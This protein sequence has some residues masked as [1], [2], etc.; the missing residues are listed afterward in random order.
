MVSGPSTIEEISIDL[1]LNYTLGQ[2]TVGVFHDQAILERNPDGSYVIA[3]SALPMVVF[4][5]RETFGLDLLEQILQ[6]QG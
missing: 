5:L 6:T 1:G 3:E 2:R 4:V